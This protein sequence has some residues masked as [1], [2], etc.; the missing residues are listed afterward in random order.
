M[1]N[2]DRLARSILW[3]FIMLGAVFLAVSFWL[4]LRE[5]SRLKAISFPDIITTQP[6]IGR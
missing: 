1:M 2:P 4:D 3:T 5:S 6:K